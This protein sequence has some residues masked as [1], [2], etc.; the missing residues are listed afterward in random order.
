MSIEHIQDFYLSW[1]S[2]VKNED[3]CQLLLINPSDLAKDLLK[4]Q[5]ELFEAC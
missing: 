1:S 2:P 5:D 3:D 4:R